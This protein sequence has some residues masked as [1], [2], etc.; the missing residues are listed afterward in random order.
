[1]VNK[2]DVAVRDSFRGVPTL[3]HALSNE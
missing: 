3:A 1:M 2:I